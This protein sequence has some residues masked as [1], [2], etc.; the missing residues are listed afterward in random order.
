[1][2]RAYVA[3]EEQASIIRRDNLERVA[4]IRPLRAVLVLEHVFAQTLD[5]TPSELDG[6]GR[7]V[8]SVQQ[9]FHVGHLWV[10]EAAARDLPQVSLEDALW[11]VHLYAERE[12]PNPSK[13]RCAGRH[14]TSE[15]SPSLHEFANVALSLAS[16]S[17]TAAG[18][19]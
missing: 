14:A 12:S 8:G 17:K 9:R 7:D 1:M 18:A 15:S 19:G 3:T 2:T 5:V 13:R 11:L 6:F 4:V 16:R 10:A